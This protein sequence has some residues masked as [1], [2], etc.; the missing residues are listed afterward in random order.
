MASK[1]VER[2]SLDVLLKKPPRTKV[3]EVELADDQ[4]VSILFRAIGSKAYDDLLGSHPPSKRDKEIGGVWNSDTFPPSLI[5]ACAV[6]PEIS[7]EA[8]KEIFAS[9]DWSRGE[10]MDMFMKVVT[11]NSEGMNIPFTQSD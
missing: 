7:E 6:E 2:A 4:K 3:I 10:L 11:L 5:A 1:K 8:A 9:E